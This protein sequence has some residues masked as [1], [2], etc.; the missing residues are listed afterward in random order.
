MRKTL[1]QKFVESVKPSDRRADYWDDAVRGLSL[2]VAPAPS[3]VKTW[4]CLYRN[5]TDR[6]VKRVTVGRFPLVSLAEARKA[7]RPILRDASLGLDPAA[8]KK[9]KRD[10][11]SFADLARTYIERHAKIKKRSWEDDQRILDHDLLPAWRDRKADSIERKDI[12]A[13]LNSIMDRGSGVMA[14]RTLSCISKIFAFG[15]GQ[16]LVK[17]NPAYK[18]PKPAP[19]TRTIGF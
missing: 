7:A 6:K 10:A 9:E 16:D 19:S 12:I 3:D 17:I 5:K 13:M 2:R 18:V 15:V 14:N 1:T 11:S 8:A 4:C